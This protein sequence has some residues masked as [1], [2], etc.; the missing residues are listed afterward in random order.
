MLSV[1][2]TLKIEVRSNKM[3]E[4]PR[5]GSLTPLSAIAALRA[6]VPGNRFGG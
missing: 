6:L 2:A 3:P 4:N 1:A 5:T